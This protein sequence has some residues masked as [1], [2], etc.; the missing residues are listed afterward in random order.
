MPKL[1]TIEGIDGAGKTTAISALEEIADAPVITTEPNDGEIYDAEWNTTEW[2]G[3]QVRTAIST[4][5]VDKVSVFLYFL[6]DHAH[7]YA[8]TVKPALD[9]GHDVFCDRYIGS[10]YAYQSLSLSDRID[11]DSLSYLSTI[12]ESE[13]DIDID[14]EEVQTVLRTA[15]DEIPADIYDATPLIGRYA[16][17]LAC[18]PEFIPQTLT[19]PSF[20]FPGLTI[21]DAPA[22]WSKLPDHTI[23]LDIPVSVSLER[24]GSEGDEV[25][26]KEAFLKQVREQYLKVAE[27]NPDRFTIIDATQPKDV[28]KSEVQAVLMGQ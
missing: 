17:G 12:Q 1:T 24:L 21:C 27:R 10:R 16:Y 15:K 2:F 14:N 8:T 5:T 19:D 20:D 13:L 3:N 25:F 4:D 7:H 6:A 18:H 11:G 22:S 23:L 26:E 28:V 9:N